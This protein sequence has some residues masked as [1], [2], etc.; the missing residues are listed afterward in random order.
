MAQMSK[1]P[2]F[3]QHLPAKCSFF[4]LLF[5]EGYY[6]SIEI[7]LPN[8]LS[9]AFIFRQEFYS[10]ASGLKI[11]DHG[12]SDNNLESLCICERNAIT[13]GT[14]CVKQHSS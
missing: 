10:I 4:P 13:V 2:G 7:T 11:T 5:G 8:I 9:Y 12:N 6:Q 1:L 14:E 3:D